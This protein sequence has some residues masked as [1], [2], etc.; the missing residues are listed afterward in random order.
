[1][2]NCIKHFHLFFQENFSVYYFLSEGTGTNLFSGVAKTLEKNYV[3]KI[4]L[5]VK[6]TDYA[7]ILISIKNVERYILKFI[8]ACIGLT[9]AL[10]FRLWFL[11]NVMCFLGTSFRFFRLNCGT[12][13]R[14][15][16][17]RRW[18]DRRHMFMSATKL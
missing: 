5:R 10:S 4:G 15:C 8:Y 11:K 7:S 3:P 9:S 16:S 2:Y 12:V 17:Q 18:G 13:V 14:A 6:R 1:M